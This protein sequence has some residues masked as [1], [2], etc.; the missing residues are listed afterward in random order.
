M[1]RL[2]REPNIIATV[3]MWSITTLILA[4]LLLA[5]FSLKAPAAIQVL[6][7]PVIGAGSNVLITGGNSKKDAV[8]HQGYAGH[9]YLSVNTPGGASLL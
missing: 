5:R 1:I 6:C 4:S 9:F 3:F 7:W 8:E 2:R